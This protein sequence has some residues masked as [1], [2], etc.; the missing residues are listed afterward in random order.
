MSKILIELMTERNI[1][2]SGKRTCL[3]VTSGGL[4][5]LPMPGI[6]SYC[7][8]KI[9]VSRFCEATAEEVRSSGVDVMAWEAGPVNTALN[10]MN[11]TFNLSC[12]TAVKGCFS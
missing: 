11:S 9:A 12:K 10:P 2:K 5:Y 7:S 4:A 8:S 3:V 1:K 6:L